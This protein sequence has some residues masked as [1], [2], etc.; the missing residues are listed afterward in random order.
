MVSG[1]FRQ[2]LKLIDFGCAID[3]RASG[4]TFPLTPG[5][6]KGG[7]IEYMAPEIQRAKTGDQLDYSK[8]DEF[9]AGAHLNLTR[10]P[11]A[12]HLRALFSYHL[13]PIH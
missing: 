2:F 8:N 3:V 13:A 1:G 5:G 10:W 4:F 9:S 6:S 11:E 12:V 7:A